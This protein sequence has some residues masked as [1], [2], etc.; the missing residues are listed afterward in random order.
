V[1]APNGATNVF[2]CP[3]GTGE[4]PDPGGPAPAP[5]GNGAANVDPQAVGVWE[6]SN[7]SGVDYTNGSGS[8]SSPS[9]NKAIFQFTADG[10][11]LFEDFMQSSLSSCTMA[12]L[13]RETGSVTFHGSGFTLAPSSATVTSQDSC[14]ASN[15]YQKPWQNR[16]DGPFEYSW[17]VAANPNGGG[18]IMTITYLGDG[19][20][21]TLLEQPS[22]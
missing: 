15:N 5:G 8:Y 17:T 6:N 3:S 7:T 13:G 22:Q 11:Y 10:Q 2:C 20:M 1:A 21:E 16:L 19:S 9:G 4:S 14:N 18:R 12:V